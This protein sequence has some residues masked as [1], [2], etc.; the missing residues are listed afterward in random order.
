MPKP[1]PATD[2]RQDGF[3]RSV[4]LKRD[5]VP[6]LR[7]HPYTI[8]SIA[9]MGEVVFDP[10]VTFFTGEN[11]SGKSTLL[12]GIAVAWGFNA[13]GGGRD[14]LFSTRDSHSDLFKY[15]RLVKGTFRPGDGF[16][17]RAESFFNFATE[18]ERANPSMLPYG[19]V[20]LHEMS[21]G[22]SFLALLTNRFRKNGLFLLDEPEAAL[23]PSRRLAALGVI[24]R[25]V[26]TGSQFLIATHCP[27]LLA[28]PGARI[29]EFGEDGIRPISYEETEPYAVT[30]AF[31][32]RRER[33]VREILS[34]AES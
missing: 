34:E 30:R 26:R 27:I 21:H 5:R 13:E 33:M 14:H 31:L 23:S 24:H 9:R 11:G 25:L 18:I 6:D 28:Y 4:S 29:L 20:P 8:P 16:F 32:E 7:E 2:F 10:R 17:L 12:E 1:N 3:L 15:L 22:E 19:G